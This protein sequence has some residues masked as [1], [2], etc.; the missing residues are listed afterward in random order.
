MDEDPRIRGFAQSLKNG[1]RARNIPSGP[2]GRSFGRFVGSRA[3]FY[4]Q[5]FYLIMLP[6]G[7]QQQ[8]PI[9]SA[10]K[11]CPGPGNPST[12]DCRYHSNNKHPVG[13][14]DPRPMHRINLI[15]KRRIGSC[16]G[17]GVSRPGGQLLP[18]LR[19]FRPFQ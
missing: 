1:G 3:E 12:I 2:S 13:P 9:P 10:I 7:V 4:A 6:N 18:E 19:R 17:R 16:D 5:S 11:R 14:G 8:I 15:Q